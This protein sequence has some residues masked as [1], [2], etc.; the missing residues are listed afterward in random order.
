MDDWSDSSIGD[1]Q[2]RVQYQFTPES[3]D[4]D[5][6]IPIY[7]TSNKVRI[8]PKDFGKQRELIGNLLGTSSTAG[9][10]IAKTY[11]PFIEFSISKHED[12]SKN[13]FSLFGSRFY[14]EKE[15]KQ[16]RGFLI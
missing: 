6:I 9:D 1:A 12:Y 5:V 2:Y 10:D 4:N 11:T 7:T 15:T 16:A 8:L 13:Y 3:K 14:Y